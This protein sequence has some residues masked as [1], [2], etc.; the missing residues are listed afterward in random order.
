VVTEVAAPDEHGSFEEITDPTHCDRKYALRFPD[1]IQFSRS[2][3]RVRS[4][5]SLSMA[6]HLWG[7]NAN[8]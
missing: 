5:R 3:S 4:T 2:S 8:A 6:R 1:R 7:E